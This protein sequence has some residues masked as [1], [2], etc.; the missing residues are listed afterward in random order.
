MITSK[1]REILTFIF[2]ILLA[3]TVYTQ[4]LS[5]NQSST[6]HLS[7]KG[8]LGL[9]GRWQAG[10]LNQVNLMPKG[11]ISFNNSSYYAQF[12]TSYHFL[13]VGDFNAINDL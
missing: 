10:N 5:K 9:I 2:L 13:M 7:V 12:N 8:R 11:S 4:S 3:S 1:K 6:D